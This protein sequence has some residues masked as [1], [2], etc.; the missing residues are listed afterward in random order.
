MKLIELIGVFQTV[1]AHGSFLPPRP[2]LLP[3][4]EGEYGGRGWA[5]R[6]VPVTFAGDEGCFGKVRS[7]WIFQVL[8]EHP[9]WL[10]VALRFGKGST[11]SRPTVRSGSALL[12]GGA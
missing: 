6:M 12:G 3:W 9:F 8:P 7:V 1:F 2:G 10:L 11:E 5:N 4:G